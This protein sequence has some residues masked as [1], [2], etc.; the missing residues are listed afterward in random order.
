MSKNNLFKELD[1]SNKVSRNGFN[2]SASNKFT[3]KCGEL[4]PVYH[5]V[6]IPGDSFKCSVNSFTRTAP[7]ETAAFT[8]F[9]EYY[10]WF[11]VPYRVLGKQIPNIL[12]KNT[13]NPSI[14]SSSTTN[15]PVGSELP[16]IT[17]YNYFGTNTSEGS[18]RYLDVLLNYQNEFGFNRGYL[19]AKLMS[20]LGYCYID[21]KSLEALSSGTNSG[22]SLPYRVDLKVSILPLMAYQKIYYDFYRNSQWEDNVPYNYNVDYM[23]RN[24]TFFVPATNNNN[25]YN[26]YYDNPTVF[27]LRYANYPKDLFMGLLPDSQYGDEAVMEMDVNNVV[28]DF[29]P[30]ITEDEIAVVVGSG[31][32]GDPQDHAIRGRNN[33]DL[34][35]DKALGLKMRNVLDSLNAGISVLQERK[36]RALQKYK[37]ILGSGSVDYQTIIRKIFNVDVPDT[38]ADHCIYLG[39]SSFVIDVN[40][41]ENTNLNTEDSAIQRGKGI[42]S[43]NGD[44]IEFNSDE[45][46][47]IM[48]IY[49]CA[50]IIDYALSGINF[51]VTKVTA[52]DYPNPV[53]DN[54]GFV[55]FPTYYLTNGNF[56]SGD[57]G[58]P[59]YFIGYTTRYFDCKTHVD[60]TLGA[61]RES[62]QSWIAPIDDEYLLQRPDGWVR[63]LDYTFFK[64][65]PRIVDKI[66]AVDCDDTVNT[67]QFRVCATFN[68]HAVRN[69]NYL[70][71]PF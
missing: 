11:F 20:H 48:C 55:E 29:V 27:D 44:T 14:A 46:G 34:T 39:G 70:G 25:V 45:F 63:E 17:L 61:F 4:L 26:T 53:F 41:V 42:G 7:L 62:L 33:S 51:D 50:P 59:Y 40:E 15:Q 9:K 13:K 71:V 60:Q 32:Q 19:S 28:N 16:N 6:V 56:W 65:N 21:T 1:V 31:D 47:V 49:H 23:S 52:D 24:M 38:L 8:K 30:L 67:D 5:K 10:D 66:F 69:L 18:P 2:L 54:L 37:E 3:A 68:V 57:A 43:G 58:L 12:A 35:Y 22:Y 64:I 36:A